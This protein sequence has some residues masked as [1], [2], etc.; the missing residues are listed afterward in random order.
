AD[1]DVLF[2]DDD[3]LIEIEDDDDVDAAADDRDDDSDDD[4]S[5]A[6]E[7]G[8]DETE[9]DAAIVDRLVNGTVEVPPFP[10]IVIQLQQ[11]AGRGAG[12]SSFVDVVARDPALAAR[13]LR[14]AN[15]ASYARAEKITTLAQAVGAVGTTMLMRLALADGLGAAVTGDG[16]LLVLRDAAWRNAVGGA[17]L[18][19]ALAP[20]RGLPPDETFVCALLHD[21]GRLLAVR[22]IEDIVKDKTIPFVDAVSASVWDEIV[23][24][25]RYELGIVA[26]ERWRLPDEIRS[27]IAIDPSRTGGHP[28]EAMLQLLHGVDRVTNLLDRQG[29]VDIDD[30]CAVSGFGIRDADVL[31]RALPAL[32]ALIT[33]FTIERLSAPRPAAVGRVDQLGPTTSVKK[34]SAT[35][36]GM[37]QTKQFLVQELSSRG[38]VLVGGAGLP[39]QQVFQLRFERPTTAASTI[40]DRPLT[41]WMR[42][43]ATTQVGVSWQVLAT[44]FALSGEDLLRWQAW[45]RALSTL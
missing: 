28:R 25:Y 24:R 40:V 45:T 30:V 4:D 26:A 42:V 20:L 14:V 1:A 27:V 35:T 3:D 10:Q 31:V 5:E 16:P 12:L 15:A 29:C 34:L 11:L 37:T 9:L 38:V 7:I 32:P 19:S 17:L 21:F 2:A 13:V 22:V 18:S 6:I 44:P 33:S 8:I 36:V 39:A 41:V 23:D 43:L